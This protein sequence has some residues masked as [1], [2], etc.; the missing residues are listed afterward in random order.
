ML[1]V[2][3]EG[4][5]GPLDGLVELGDELLVRNL[6]LGGGEARRERALLRLHRGQRLL[7]LEGVEGL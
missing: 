1:V 3:E 2:E 6:Q 7:E 5:D 4:G